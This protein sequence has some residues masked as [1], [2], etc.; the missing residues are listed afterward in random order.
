MTDLLESE[1]V[2]MD[3]ALQAQH[4][5]AEKML[6]LDGE[7]LSF[8]R[9]KAQTFI[10]KTLAIP[11]NSPD[12]QHQTEVIYTLANN[13]IKQAAQYANHILDQPVS[14]CQ[15]NV[16]Q[17]VGDSIAQLRM[18]VEDLSPTPE[19][20][21]V[22]RK[23]F[24]LIPWGN[25]VREYFSRYESAQGHLNAIIEELLAGKDALLRDNA[26]IEEERIRL[27][28]LLLTLREYAVLGK[29]LDEVLCQRIAE[30]ALDDEGTAEELKKHLL[31]YLRQKQM[32]ILTQLAVSMQGYMALDVI[33]KNNFELIKGVDRATNSTVSALRTAVITAQ[34]LTQQKLVLSQINVLNETTGRLIAQTAQMMQ[35]QAGQ[36]QQKASS[37]NI[38]LE[39]L[40]TAFRHIYAA[41]DTLDDYKSKALGDMAQTIEAL[42]EESTKAQSY[43]QR[44]YQQDPSERQEDQSDNNPLQLEL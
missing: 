10:E 41:I 25:R 37:A 16:D 7:K 26:S 24:G 30:I 14:R 31:F 9:N 27:W 28:Q 23:L 3:G 4:D 33:R 19:N 15:K 42:R 29:Y 34:A 39:Q 2:I 21:F 32:D 6:P 40:K 43:L 36:I 12:F 8:L 20:I 11:I 44:E 22:Q 38:E 5:Q 13:A 35:E 18:L 1:I 17:G